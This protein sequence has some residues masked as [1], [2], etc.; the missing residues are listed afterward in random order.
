M[1][2]GDIK[3]LDAWIEQ[4]LDVCDPEDLWFVVIR[5]NRKGSYA[6]FDQKHL[7]SFTVE[8]HARY[9]TFVITEFEPFFEQ[10]KLKIAELAYTAGV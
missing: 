2:N 7:D 4:T 5:I 8:N 6:C 10:N 1:C 9:K 3:Q